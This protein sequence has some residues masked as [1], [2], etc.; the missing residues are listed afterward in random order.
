VER[1]DLLHAL[2]AEVYEL[3]LLH[4]LRLSIHGDAFQGVEGLLEL[5]ELEA[6][7]RG[8]IVAVENVRVDLGRMVEPLSCI[9]LLV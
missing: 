4:A 5:L 1:A 2:R 8:A 9:A 3:L 6:A 7:E